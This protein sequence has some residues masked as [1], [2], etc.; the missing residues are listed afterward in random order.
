ME[1]QRPTIVVHGGAGEW[2]PDRQNLGIL[3]VKRAAKAGFDV[4][5][6]SGTAL[7]AVEAAVMM[8]EDDSTFNAGL[9]SSLNLEKSV[10]MEASIMDG[11][12]LKAGATALLTNIRNPIHLARIIMEKTDH[13]FIA[14]K[15]AQRLGE[16][17]NLEKANPVTKL[18]E[19]HWLD[20]KNKIRQGTSG[21]LPK[22]SNLMKSYPEFM[23]AD[24]VGAIAIDQLGNVAA[25]TSTGG[26]T[27]KI[28]GRIGDSPLIGCGN[29]ADNKIGAC[30]ATG[31]GEIAMKLVLAKSAC[32]L[33]H[34]GYS[35]QEAAEILIKRV[36]QAIQNTPNQMGLIA[37]D[38]KGRI[39]A[40]HNSHHLC[41]SYMTPLMKSP[42]ASLTAKIVKS[43]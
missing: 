38:K 7:D 19:R 27:F 21:Y 18:R 11:E 31:I 43:G 28:P 13:I 15:S 25:A 20:L 24:T 33:I 14:G 40:A 5:R 23:N 29:Y 1:S 16:I 32:C 6:R 3:G 12:T 4:L 35:P 17:F 41:W 9:G 34:K 10:E 22:L 8:M 36:N 30:S 37:I 2:K 42:K 26:L 39:G